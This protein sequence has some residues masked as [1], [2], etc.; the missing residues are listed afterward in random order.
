[1]R[2]RLLLIV[3]AIVLLLGAVLLVLRLAA[4]RGGTASEMDTTEG[5][6][7]PE[8]GARATST[9]TTEAFTL[10]SLA[11]PE[12]WTGL[13]DADADGL[14]DEVE[15][16]YGTDP[17]NRDTDGDG[18][19]DGDELRSGYH[20]LRKEGNPRLD[21][22]NDGLFENEECQWKTDPKN[23]DTDGDGFS[24]GEEVKNTFDP[25][26]RGDGTGSDALPERRA[27]DAQKV[28]ERFR[29]N[30][31]SENLTERL[32]AQLFGNRPIAEL[33]TFSP[34]AADIQR[35]IDAMPRD[36]RLP[37]VALTE[38]S[39]APENTPAAI[40]SYLDA[41][42]LAEPLPV[43]PTTLSGSMNAAFQG[44]AL[45]L[46]GIR[47]QLETYERTLLG[48][49]VPAT[50]VTYH[51]RLI[52]F[53]RFTSSRFR[54]IEEQGVRDPVRAYLALRELQ[55]GAPLHTETLVNLRSEL[56]RLAGSG[57]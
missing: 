24:D 19:T 40:R 31:T 5:A 14:P 43:D 3:V 17:G 28:L 20:P 11:C 6:T 26:K 25:T 16:L 46:A 44:N 50:A 9:P 35:A 8:S 2:Q 52:G 1:M 38:L 42:R 18:F 4:N 37:T 55:E 51:Q 57:T 47:Q 27:L 32:A 45:A 33:T 15:T 13:P 29:P 56:E 30:P 7:L 12:R 34:S 36:T 54:T 21:S 23:P 53:V 22:D 39:V 10:V 41:V 49:R 48:T